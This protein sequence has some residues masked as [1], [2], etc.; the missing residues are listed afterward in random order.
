MAPRP[1]PAAICSIERL[2]A[3]DFVL[4]GD[5]VHLEAMV[6]AQARPIVSLAL[7]AAMPSRGA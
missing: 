5:V 6:S 7:A 1:L 2:E 4:C 3:T